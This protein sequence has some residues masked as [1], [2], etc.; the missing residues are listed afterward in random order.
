MWT[1][2]SADN[3]TEAD[4]DAR[5]SPFLNVAQ[6]VAVRIRAS[7]GRGSA[8]SLVWETSGKDWEANISARESKS[9]NHG[10]G[11]SLLG[12]GDIVPSPAG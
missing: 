9:N 10:S 1:C 3:V 6:I 8:F 7:D 5:K 12:N 11:M 2:C 4:T